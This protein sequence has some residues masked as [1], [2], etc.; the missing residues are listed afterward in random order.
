MQRI[1]KLKVSA[2]CLGGLHFGLYQ[3]EKQTKKIIDTAIDY[4][5]NFIETAPMYGEGLSEKMIGLAIKNK[6]D[7]V[8]ISTKVGLEPTKINGQFSVNPIKLTYNNIIKSVDNSLKALGLEK[9]G[10]FQLHSFDEITP[11]IETLSAL[12]RLV[13]Q[14]K[15]GAIG[16]SNYNESELSRMLNELKKFDLPVV[17]FQ[18]HYNLLERRAEYDLFPTCFKERLGVLCNRGLARGLLSGQYKK[19]GELPYNSRAS[20]S[21]RI[22]SLLNENVIKL[23]AD[24]SDFSKGNG[25]TLAQL[26]LK[27]ALR[28]KEVMS[29]A[30]G[31]QNCDQLKEL[32]LG[33]EKDC[34]TSI[35]NEVDNIISAHKLMDS[36]KSKPKDFLEK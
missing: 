32:V 19:L 35:L 29:I 22:R 27:W 23:I 7:E 28:R 6:K 13:D 20:K 5:I 14:G 26:S 18:A 25:F 17:S 21:Q 8:L 9:I 3:N 4:G 16:V 11:V 36:V 15:I 34:D 33:I 2:L 31:V 10:L 1:F 24:L 12:D 30:I